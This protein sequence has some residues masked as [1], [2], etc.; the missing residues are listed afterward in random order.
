MIDH[1]VDDRLSA[2]GPVA[3]ELTAS[4]ESPWSRRTAVLAVELKDMKLTVRHG[5]RVLVERELEREELVDLVDTLLL[6]GNNERDAD[7]ISMRGTFTAQ[8]VTLPIALGRYGDGLIEPLVR[9][10]GDA[11]YTETKRP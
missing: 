8:G 6:L 11:E 7:S 2:L 4:H 5:R 3:L 1:Y 10:I 9:A